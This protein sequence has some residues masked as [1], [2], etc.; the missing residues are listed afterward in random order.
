MRVEAARVILP[1]QIRDILPTQH[2]PLSLTARGT[3]DHEHRER[4]N[5]HQPKPNRHA[6]TGSQLSPAGTASQ[7]TKRG[8]EDCSSTRLS[9]VE[10]YKLSSNGLY[11]L[12]GT[13]ERVCKV[14]Y[15][16]QRR[17]KHRR[18]SVFLGKAR[19]MALLNFNRLD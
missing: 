13:R 17:E 7:R 5:H 14:T 9:H 3:P 4:G 15:P 1:Y 2:A 18:E 6:G 10:L 8:D 19:Q 11:T 12:F 16:L